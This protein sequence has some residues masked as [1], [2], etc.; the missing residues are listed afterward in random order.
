[1]KRKLIFVIIA[2]IILGSTIWY[3][4]FFHKPV[5]PIDKLIGN[6]YDYAVKSYFHSEPSSSTTFNINKDLYEFQRGVLSK[7]T[8]VTLTSQI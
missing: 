4:D 2:I 8:N 1:M 5:E 3:F 7:T 6:N